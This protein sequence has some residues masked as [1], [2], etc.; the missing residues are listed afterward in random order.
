[1][2]PDDESETSTRIGCG[3][4]GYANSKHSFTIADY[5]PFTPENDPDVHF[6]LKIIY[7]IIFSGGEWHVSWTIISL[8]KHSVF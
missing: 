4:I 5:T 6:R 1:M 7:F 3:V 2:H 8:E